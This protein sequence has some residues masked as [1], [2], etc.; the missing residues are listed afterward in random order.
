M[1]VFVI[2]AVTSVT[3]SLKYSIVFIALFFYFCKWMICLNFLFLSLLVL[4]F[5]FF[6]KIPPKPPPTKKPPSLPTL[7]Q[8]AKTDMS[9]SRVIPPYWAVKIRSVGP[10]LGTTLWMCPL[11]SAEYRALPRSCVTACPCPEL[12]LGWALGTHYSF[13]LF[14]CFSFEPESWFPK[15][16]KHGH[17]GGRKP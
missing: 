4:V 15:K 1:S 5:I 8:R 12:I 11:L 13:F 6:K 17:E 14:L 3:L 16:R 10:K 2:K 9:W 7:P